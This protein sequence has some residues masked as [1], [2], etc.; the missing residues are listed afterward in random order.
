MVKNIEPWV[1]LGRPRE[2]V[3]LPPNNSSKETFK[4][5]RE[6]LL[7]KKLLDESKKIEA[8]EKTRC[9]HS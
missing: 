7:K 4:M 1:R 8:P 3:M 2:R 6:K 9:S 5:F